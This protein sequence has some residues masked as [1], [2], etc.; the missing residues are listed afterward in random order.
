LP[1]ASRRLDL[2]PQDRPLR[3]PL[4]AGN[5]KMHTTVATGTDLARAVAGATEPHAGAVEVVVAPPY[6]GLAAVA[7]ALQGSH[8]RVGAQDC[9]W[10]DAGAFTGAIGPVMVRELATHVILGHSERRE[11]FGETNE[12]INRKIH[13]A[14]HHG[15]APIVCVGESL[16]QREAG[17]T[18]HVVSVQ[19][20]ACLAGLAPREAAALAVAYEPVWAIGTGQ[21]CDAAE[22]Q[23]VCAM[24]RR[25]VAAGCG[26]DAAGALRVLYG[27]SV[28]PDNAADYLAAPD[29]DGA[30]VGGASLDAA[31]FAAIVDAAAGA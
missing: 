25:R 30:L 11:L 28:K 23:R 27:G 20:D 24:I 12:D 10:A 22:A 26:D 15:L 31:S 4:V 9:H 6:T 16:A 1:V 21:A 7:A 14:L 5:W 3:T 13:A 18:D 29:I 2:A 8:V 17:E 19:L